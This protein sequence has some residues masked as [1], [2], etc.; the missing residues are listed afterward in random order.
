MSALIKQKLE[1]DIKNIPL[2]KMTFLFNEGLVIV[3]VLQMNVYEEHEGGGSL[4]IRL[5]ATFTS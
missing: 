3:L 5:D 1:K 4:K 2:E